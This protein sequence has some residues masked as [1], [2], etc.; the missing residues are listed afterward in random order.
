M[1]NN[2][3]N[4]L[5]T[6]ISQF[7]KLETNALEVFDKLNEAIT[8]NKKTVDID[9]FDQNNNLV[10][11]QVPGFGYIK[12]ELNRIDNNVKNLAG[13]G[14]SDTNV[15]LSDGTYRKII[16]S[17][18]KTPAN[19]ISSVA[20]PKTFQSKSNWFF[21]QFLNPLLYIGIDVS[22]QIPVDTE[23]I[24]VKR[25]IINLD[26][27]KKKQH[28]NDVYK[29]KDG[30]T[31]SN[32]VNDILAN[33]IS[34]VLDEET[35][36]V[37]PRALRYVG[38]FSVL[39]IKNK[40]EDI[41]IDGQT[42]K[43][44][45]QIY[46][47]DKLT[48][49]DLNSGFTDSVSLKIGDSVIVNNSRKNTRYIVKAIDSSTNEVGLELVE[50]FDAINIG[51]SIISIYKGQDENIQL[52]I[53]IGFDEN[54]V[55]F[56]KAVDPT[57]KI[58][59]EF[60]SPGIGFYSNELEIL[61]NNGSVQTLETY[62]KNQVADI[63]NILLGLAKDKM[64]PSVYASEPNIPV[65][66]SA[67][68]SVTQ[69]NRHLTD[70]DSFKEVQQSNDEKNKLTAEIKEADVSIKRKRA[71]IATKKYDSTIEKQADIKELQNL[72]ESRANSSKLYSSI[73]NNIVDKAKGEHLVEISAK[74][75]VRGFWSIPEP[76]ASKFTNPQ[77][78]VQFVVQYRYLSTTGKPNNAAQLNFKD[79]NNVERR[80]TFS[81]WIE[82]RTKARQR[83]KNEI[84]GQFE[85]HVEDVESADAININ[86]LDIPIQANESV[87]IRIKS[88]S[89][90]G[91][92]SNPKESEWSDSVIVNFPQELIQMN[93]LSTIKEENS[94]ELAKVKLVEELESKGIDEHLASSFAVNE[95]YYAH[96]ATV[97][98]SG[99]LSPE[100]KPV[101]L[102]DKLVEFENRI[103]Q[104]QLIIDKV[105][106]ELVIK[107]LDDTGAENLIENN[108]FN[109]FFAGYYVDAIKD[110]DI[111]KG[112]IVT[113]TYFIT[114]ENNVATPLE[115]ISRMPGNRLNQLP[116]SG[117]VFND[118]MS[119][120]NDSYYTSR[121]KY[122][123]VPVVLTNPQNINAFT[124]DSPNQSAQRF[125]QFLYARW[126]NVAGTD[127]FY[128]DFNVDTV[129]T[130]L[131]T[132]I[133]IAEYSLNMTP[134]A[135]SGAGLTSVSDFIWS[136]DYSGVNANVTSLL[137]VGQS[138]YN[139][140]IFVH[141]MHPNVI[142]NPSYS[143]VNGNDDMRI[144]K[145][146]TLTADNIYGKRQVGY[147][148]DS[149]LPIPRTVKCSFEPD[150]Q[151]LL[152]G[153]SCGA[154]M[155]I[156][157]ND[158]TS[159]QVNGDDDLS[160]IKISIGQNSAIQIP[161]VYQYR[162]TDF[163]GVG[164]DG[165]GFVAG[166]CTGT[167]KDITYSKRMGF[168]IKLASGEM[169]KFD[170]EFYSKYRSNNLNIDK[171]PRRD[172]R[173]A[174]ED[175]RQTLKGGVVPN[176]IERPTKDVSGIK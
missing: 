63:G 71:L 53:P 51:T 139:S 150:D 130:D 32:F 43:T 166:D 19:T 30:F 148:Y 50:G 101:N 129:N 95:Y 74:Y 55:I 171:I 42:V 140:N 87:E 106:G 65:L 92:P 125:G 41:L 24:I 163:G 46:K 147:F 157:V 39:R 149:T 135:H 138:T 111:K 143:L 96:D 167:T 66:N 13:T 7:L 116:I 152:G 93:D 118:P 97:I 11:I 160:N 22:G 173:L 174:V 145:A 67:N 84:T 131:I 21:E 94:I 158:E 59:A 172:I 104:L 79:N 98:A 141:W 121:A 73:V 78:I 70:N 175:L 72:I 115:I 49:T 89:E 159:L 103:N 108:S 102:Y 64:P 62:Y 25:Y 110:R 151:Y 146:A 156:A 60:W 16:T 133:N 113:K 142:N 14:D 82:I 168:D 58:P 2:T 15:R 81:N 33:N 26:T 12:N 38:N 99:F 80:G 132:N 123:R 88:I 91:Y 126:M 3:N 105:T 68:F 31:Y 27:E 170:V 35:L 76:K 52:E 40:Q 162:M 86:Q 36:D 164:T 29:G 127:A 119:V 4:S 134:Y 124:F 44:R 120:V 20:V 117:G 112:S 9:L 165:L 144:A 5:S 114:I 176:I 45:S 23:K 69:I 75:R 109:K 128:L 1:S 37:P 28:F 100:Q 137:T 34:F 54:A 56:V 17:K 83:I 90:A 8:S 122:D 6:L 47:L 155:F 48:Y 10:R 61:Q 161:L 154:Y 107:L 153:K 57:S 169:F 77:E 18:L 85:W 136:G